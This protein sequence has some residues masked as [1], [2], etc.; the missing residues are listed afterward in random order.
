VSDRD[1]RTVSDAVAARAARAASAV[2]AEALR[3]DL[4]DLLASQSI[5]GDEGAA[6][7]AVARRMAGAGLEVRAWDA[8]PVALARDPEHPG[9]EVPRSSLPH[10]SP[11]P[12][13]PWSA[14]RN[15][16]CGSHRLPFPWDRRPS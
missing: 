2:D 3:A 15:R 11:Q 14:R 4:L 10:P 6:R 8:D 16:S 1:A 13:S 12:L 5:T 7:D 9:S